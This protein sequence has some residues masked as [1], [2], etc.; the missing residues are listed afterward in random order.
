MLKTFARRASAA[1]LAGACLLGTAAAQGP[2][3]LK[4]VVP[5]PAGGT[6]DILPRVVAEK[7]RAQFPGGVVIDN[8][9]GAG[10]NIGAEMVFRSEPDGNTLMVS[11]PAPIAINQHLYKK[12]S[13]DPSKWVPVTVLA[14]V[15]NV[16]VVN[17]KL[18]VKNVQ[19]FIAYAKANPGK[20]SYGSQ[21][22]GTTSHLTASMFMQLTGVEMVHIPY[23]GT[24]PALVD[25]VGGQIDVF[26]DNLSSSLPFHQAGKLRILGV[27]DGQRSPA[28]PDVPTFAEQKLPAMNAVTWFA[29]VAPPGTPASKVASTQKAIADALAH[30]EVKQKFAEQG[31]EPRGW[32]SAQ[33]GKFIQ[34]ESAKWDKVIK[35]A[36]VSLD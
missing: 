7:L 26:F 23:K 33:T 5:Y 21:G 36:K 28:L 17:P 24:A 34:A 35:S 11:P 1:C 13:F 15:P 9:T 6:A 8:R 25:L 3:A 30:P 32:D 10:G 2:Q 20:L 31:A 19:E 18:P 12:L 4:L 22:N 16:L 29:V 27:A 14:T